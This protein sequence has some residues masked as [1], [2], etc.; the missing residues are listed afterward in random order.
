MTNDQKYDY[1][2]VGQGIAGS[3]LAWTLH[4]RGHRVLIINNSAAP[5]SSKVAAGIFNP[6]TGKKLVRTWKADELFPFAHRFY[7]NLQDSLRAQL[8]HFCSVYR[9]YRSIEEQNSYWAQT[10]EPSLAKYVLPHANDAKY[11]DWVQNQYGGLEVTQSGWV[12]CGQLVEKV[13][14]FFIEKGQYIESNFDYQSVDF[15][16]NN[17]FYKNIEIKKIIFCEGFKARENL[18]F[19]W[20]PYNPVKGQTI[21]VDIEGYAIPEI[22]NQGIFILPLAQT[23]LFR[24]GAT[25]SWHDL[26]W[27]TTPEA[28]QFLEDKL[29]LLL[30]VPY[31]VVDQQAGIRPATQDRR[32][33]IG[34]HPEHSQLVIF[35]GLGSKGVSLA[36]YFAAQL[37][38][39]LEFKNE[40]DPL[41]NIERY[42][43]LYFHKKNP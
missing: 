2:I 14:S 26:D 15:Q 25:Y 42:F 20:L 7:A 40:I 31:R 22:V 19:D 38:D 43:S 34:V 29:K 24:V 18:F 3:V 23:G 37:A 10:A 27:H 35:N 39:F 21:L 33:F 6:L 13:M 9:P 16:E 5:A 30:K 12:D 17:A 1:L 4:Q 8:L 36:P 41:A 32:P 11:A 28:R